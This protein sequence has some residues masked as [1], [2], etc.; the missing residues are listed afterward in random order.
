MFNQATMR[1]S[2]ATA[3]KALSWLI[4]WGMVELL[5]GQIED[6]L[7][8]YVLI[9]YWMRLSFILPCIGAISSVSMTFCIHMPKYIWEWLLASLTV[10]GTASITV[11]SFCA[12]LA[13]NR[14]VDDVS[15]YRESVFNKNMRQS[16][17]VF[18]TILIKP[19]EGKH[20]LVQIQLAKI[21]IFFQAVQISFQV[22]L[23]LLSSGK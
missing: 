9:Q 16:V 5:A 14:V 22:W 3:I 17:R 20:H 8:V 18:R 21:G 10:K 15:K 11:F 4:V 6:S 23:Y 12:I 1:R 2:F 19:F 7:S 13:E